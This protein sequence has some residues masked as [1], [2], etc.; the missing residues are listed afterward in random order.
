[1]GLIGLG[2]VLIIIPVMIIQPLITC[3]VEKLS[4]KKN[5]ASMELNSGI[6]VPKSAAFPAPI[7]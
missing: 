3:A 7:F 5:T 4:P 6:K 1:M 2:H